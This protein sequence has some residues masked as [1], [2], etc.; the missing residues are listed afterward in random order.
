MCW[1]CDRLNWR[2]LWLDSFGVYNV[3]FADWLSQYMLLTT[4]FLQLFHS[5][6]IWTDNW[7]LTS[8]SIWLHDQKGFGFSKAAC[9]GSP[10]RERLSWKS[11][12]DNWNSKCLDVKL[13]N[14]QSQCMLLTPFF[15]QLFHSCLIWT[16]HWITHSGGKGG[17]GNGGG[18]EKPKSPAEA[19]KP[20]SQEAK[21]P[22]EAGVSWKDRVERKRRIQQRRMLWSEYNEILRCFGRKR[23]A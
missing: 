13:A 3:K 23:N 2:L 17:P 19:E 1:S 6:L 15:L 12:W 16:G 22:E 9:S 21:I 4:S 5:C 10:G 18:A 11:L 8:A 7:I 14:W 20:R